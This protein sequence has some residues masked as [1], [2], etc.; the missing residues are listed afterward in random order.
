MTGRMKA[1][2]TNA[3]LVFLNADVLTMDPTVPRAQAVAVRCGVIVDVGSNHDI[4]ERVDSQTQIVECR[5][6]CLI[7]AFHDAH[8]HLLAS[9]SRLLSVDCGPGSVRSIT[10][11]QQAIRRR[12]ELVPA[13]EWVRAGD[14]DEFYL[15]ERRHPTRW[16]LDAAAPDHPVKLQHRSHHSCVLNSL[17]L[18]LAGIDGRFQAPIGAVVEIEET[19]GE[20][21]GRLFEMEAYLNDRVVPTMK[22]ADLRAALSLVFDDLLSQG[23]TSVQD[24]T[25]R[26]GS[27]DW[28]LFRDAA[29][30]EK[31]CPRVTLMVGDEHLD[32]MVGLGLRCG[33]GDD[34]L[35][36]GPVKL[37][38]TEAG[39][40]FCPSLEELAERV[41]AA[42]SKGYP[43]AIHAVEESTVCLATEA[44]AAAGS[45][46]P[47]PRLE[48][49]SIAPPP[50]LDLI[51]ELEIGIATQPGFVYYH[52]DRY[53]VDVE[54]HLR[55]WLY[56]VKSML[57]RGIVVAAG[58]DAPIAPARPLRAVCAA[59]TR[60]SQKGQ[61]VNGGEA[62]SVE[63]ALW[64]HT[65]APAMLLGLDGK[66]GSI[67]PGKLADLA[68]LS[69]NQ[70]MLPAEEIGDI[71][72]EMTV[73]GGL[74]L[75][76]EGRA[77]PQ[78]SSRHE[79]SGREAPLHPEVGV[80]R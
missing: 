24:A 60:L 45:S 16:E 79:S 53:L 18:K 51:A 32:E 54:D 61:V 34:R 41:R 70:L 66:M 76:M 57:S 1:G 23:I 9:A 69:A 27:R 40:D 15:A 10:Q 14:Y 30:G 36:I 56:P 55:D 26:N 17:A 21:T 46:A 38:L 67:T 20:P 43:V 28:M 13:G 39:G 59:A 75:P 71:R 49:A 52:G 77:L 68:L 73:V 3:D 72:V 78:R 19:T 62:V 31:L 11:I 64:M 37:M 4:L 80:V 29:V 44:V 42:H 5:G 8:I 12:C 22:D 2:T 7:P 50:L 58:S 25:C 47:G 6:K 65:V 33:D 35:R 48:H 74:V 63:Q